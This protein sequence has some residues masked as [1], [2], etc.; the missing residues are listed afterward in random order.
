M[1]PHRE[2]RIDPP[3]HRED[4]ASLI[5]GEPRRDLRPTVLR[6]LDDQR[7]MR[8]A[9]DDAVPRREVLGERRRAE[10]AF[11][12]QRP[13]GDDRGGERRVLRRVDNVDAAAEHR[14]RVTAAAK[15][16]RVRG[17]VDPTR[18]AAHD[19]HPRLRQLLGEARRDVLPV[20]RRVPR[21]DHRDRRRVDEALAARDEIEWR[22]GELREERRILVIGT[23]NHTRTDR[24]EP[25]HLRGRLGLS[26]R[27]LAHGLRR[28]L[29]QTGGDERRNGRGE[30]GT[31]AAEAREELPPHDIADAARTPQRDPPRRV[32]LARH[33]AGILT[34]HRG[35]RKTQSSGAQ[36]RHPR[37]DEHSRRRA[38]TRSR[39]R[40]ASPRAQRYL[41]C[42]SSI[43]ARS[44]S[45]SNRACSAALRALSSRERSTSACSRFP[46]SSARC[47]SSAIALY[48]SARAL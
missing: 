26:S 44:E 21:P 25:F 6:R 31:H 34:K 13:A 42:T 35:G 36:S 4:L 5:E 11:R 22:V 18:E 9:G 47:K 41:A 39:S 10:R 29:A 43:R 45:A 2:R 32:V 20:R 30:H 33:A 37:S 28:R 15:R 24:G 48:S 12:E 23:G 46:P 27:R 38:A 7:S 1:R 19:R 16:A 8:H 40:A 17:A 3:G 14:D